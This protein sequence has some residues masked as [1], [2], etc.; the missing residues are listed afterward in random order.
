MRVLPGG[1]SGVG[2]G[3]ISLGRGVPGFGRAAAVLAGAVRLLVAALLL[4]TVLLILAL[5]D[6]SVAG[7]AVA[8]RGPS[9]GAQV[10]A[11]R[12]P[13][14]GPRTPG[15]AGSSGAPQ[16]VVERY[17]RA[18]E[19][20]A[21]QL[22]GAADAP[23]GLV[24]VAALQ[25]GTQPD[26]RGRDASGVPPRLQH[27]WSGSTAQVERKRLSNPPRVPGPDSSDV[28]SEEWPGDAV[29]TPLES[30]VP[31]L[32][33]AAAGSVKAPASGPGGP[34]Q[35][36]SVQLRNGESFS[37][38]ARRT[39]AGGVEFEKGTGPYGDPRRWPD[40]TLEFQRFRTKDGRGIPVQTRV[41]GNEIEIG[42]LPL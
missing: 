19:A 35:Q 42:E 28:R 6:Q 41:L 11:A 17:A 37:F 15:A 16:A 9:T 2:S 7:A 25:A 30:V 36:Q 21:R 26:G 18:W 20:A 8:A 14:G 38:T 40:G 33:P 10:A 23:P 39:A 31:L 27:G 34:W 1:R 5:V 4:G 32:M 24:E 3:R 29:I 22:P 13:V 12:T